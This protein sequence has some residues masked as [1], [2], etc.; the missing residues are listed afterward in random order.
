MYAYCLL[1]G[2]SSFSYVL[3]CHPLVAEVVQGQ[4]RIWPSLEIGP[5]IILNLDPIFPSLCLVPTL[6]PF[7]FSNI[8]SKS[9]VRLLKIERIEHHAITRYS[10]F[11]SK[12]HFFSSWLFMLKNYLV[13]LISS[14]Q[15]FSKLWVMKNLIFIVILERQ[16]EE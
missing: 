5:V 2:S 8:I 1:L 7:F 11:S 4:G 14:F 13:S 10:K 9:K 6:S 12:D 16:V 15:V 3:I